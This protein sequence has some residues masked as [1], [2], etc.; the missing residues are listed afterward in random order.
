MARWSFQDS[1]TIYDELL[2]VS[3]KI[4]EEYGCQTYPKGIEG[5]RDRVTAFKHG[6][7]LGILYHYT[8]GVHDVA[9][10]RWGN[11]TKWGNTVSSWHVLVL[12]RIVDNK[13]GEIWS[14]IDDELRMLFPVPTI[15]MCPFDRGTW[16]GNW[17]NNVTLGVENRNGGYHGYLKA[18][19]GLRGL[20]KEGVLF[21]GR[22]WEPY[23]REQIVSNINLGRLAD[24]WTDNQLDPDWVLTHQCVYAK[25]SDCGPCFPIH[26]IRNE[27]FDPNSETLPL[28]LSGHPLA[29]D[30][31]IEFDQEFMFSEEPRYED[32]QDYIQWAKTDI[33]EKK[34]DL[35]FAVKALRKIGFNTSPTLL[36]TKNNERLKKQ[37]RWFQRSTGCWKNSRP[38][39]YLVPDGIVGPKTI[40]GLRVRLRQLRL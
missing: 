36:D 37:V 4:L 17:A 11:H 13:I 38:E 23:T 7:Y 8:G 20:G 24:G 27:I 1:Q 15:I 3:K 26:Y 14:K 2:R 28:W 30:K 21:N 39:M 19:D 9:T 32:K 18:K 12:D 5:H 6:R 10:M 25:K 35:E 40:A 22:T 31:N 16:H 34:S 33:G 29:P